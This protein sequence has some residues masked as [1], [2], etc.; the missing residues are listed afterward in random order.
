VGP[1]YRSAIFTHN[2]EQQRTAAAVIAELT[3]AGA[4]P[5]PI[6]TE[7]TPLQAFYRAED[8]HQNYYRDNG[9]QPYCRVVIAPKVAKF[10]QQHATR[11]A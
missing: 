1:Q 3:A 4:W 8:Y 10:R 6:V 2:L 5:D 9:S 11:L 7:V